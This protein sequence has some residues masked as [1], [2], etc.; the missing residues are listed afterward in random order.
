MRRFFSDLINFI[1]YHIIS[2]NDSTSTSSNSTSSSNHNNDND[3]IKAEGK[4]ENENRFLVGGVILIIISVLI[5]AIFLIYWI[6]LI[7]RQLYTERNRIQQKQICTISAFYSN[8]NDVGYKYLYAPASI[9]ITI[10]LFCGNTSI[11]VIRYTKHVF[12]KYVDIAFYILFMIN[13]FL[14]IGLAFPLLE[15]EE[16][17]GSNDNLEN[18]EDNNNEKVE[19]TNINNNFIICGISISPR[20]S[21]HLHR[22]GATCLLFGIPFLEF[23]VS[24]TVMCGG[25]DREFMNHIV[26][27]FSIILMVFAASIIICKERAHIIWSKYYQK[28]ELTRESIDVANGLLGGE[29]T[30]YCYQCPNEFLIWFEWL[31]ILFVILFNVGIFVIELKSK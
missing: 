19:N 15:E 2:L 27:V 13:S 3:E 17:K 9:F 6:F 1:S 30:F 8:P 18:V 24:L 21:R 22:I 10:F 31:Y 26:F 14:T 16:N 29:I 23:V 11:F 4:Q 12:N 7:G 25:G 20:V 28:A 5:V